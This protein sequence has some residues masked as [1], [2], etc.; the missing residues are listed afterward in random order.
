VSTWTL[1][2]LSRRCTGPCTWR[3]L[4]TFSSGTQLVTRRSRPLV[5]ATQVS[6][7]PQLSAW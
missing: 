3:R 4:C 1:A 5:V 7:R 2:R 6:L